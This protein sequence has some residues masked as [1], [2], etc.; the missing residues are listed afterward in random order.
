MLNETSRSINASKSIAWGFVHKIL[1]ILLPFAT[2]TVI[3]HYLGVEFAGL[4]SLFTSILSVLSLTELGVGSALVFSM[5]KPVSDNDVDKINAYLYFYRKCYLVIGAIILVLGLSALPFLQFLVSGDI[6]PSVNL[7]ILYSIYLFNTSI[8]YFLFSYKS[9]ILIATQRNDVKS[10]IAS[11][12]LISKEGVQILL[13]LLFKNYYFFAICIPAFTIME[14]IA[15]AI[16]V[17]KMYPDIKACGDLDK[18]DVVQIKEKVFGLVFQKIG[19]VVLTS[20]DAIVISA[21]LGLKVLGIYN[22]Y[23]YIINALL[24]FFAIIQSSLV[25]S[26]GN[27]IV[28]SSKEKNYFDFRKF[29]FLYLGCA[30]FCASC[31]LSLYQPFM[32]IWVGEKNTLEEIGVAY[33]VYLLPAYFFFYKLNDI[34]YIYRE[35]CGLWKEWKFVNLIAALSNLVINL[36]LVNIIG[37]YG[38]VISTIV[39]LVFIYTPFF[40]YPLFSKYFESKKYFWVYLRDCLIYVVAGA[41]ISVFVYFASSFVSGD[42]V[43]FFALKLL[44]TIVSTSVLILLFAIISKTGRNS[45]LFLLAIFKRK[46][47]K[48]S[49]KK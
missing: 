41:A 6:P 5:Y 17:K 39:C 16:I 19:T 27:S 12:I 11:V 36:V 42:G 9:S 24:G 48:I 8:S 47:T 3:I 34:C 4:G 31:L 35:A 40:T 26:V 44:V 25:P 45:L 15:V 21:F 30:I 49:L 32:K 28:T 22:N 23:Y 2:R 33:V 7:Y 37:L 29:Q 10:N 1:A 13:L 46:R 38:I 18:E 14:N 20:V 43:L